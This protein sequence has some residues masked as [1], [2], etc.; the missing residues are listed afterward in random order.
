M[1]RK[2]KIGEV[3]ITF[4]NFSAIDVDYV[5]ALPNL[6]QAGVNHYTVAVII[7]PVMNT[8]RG[9]FYIVF[10][11]V[12]GIFIDSSVK[13]V[14]HGNSSKNTQGINLL[15]KPRREAHQQDNYNQ[16]RF[17]KGV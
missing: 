6:D 17:R 8:Y 7:Y 16:K 1:G 3:N 9:K 15:R 4:T 14:R 10:D 12:S 2:V 5:E 11:A 13:C